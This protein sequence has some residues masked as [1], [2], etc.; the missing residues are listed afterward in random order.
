MLLA[1]IRCLKENIRYYLNERE[2][3]TSSR[4]CDLVDFELS[5]HLVS[6]HKSESIINNNQKF[7]LNIYNCA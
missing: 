4:S 6:S 1:S 2:R 7:V 3:E 5:S